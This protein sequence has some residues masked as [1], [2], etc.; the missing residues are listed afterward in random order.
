[1]NSQVNAQAEVGND[2]DL[3]GLWTS[4]DVTRWIAGIIAG[5]IAAAI[6]MSVGGLLA[7]SQGY[8]FVFPIKLFGTTVLGNTAT[9]YGNT[10]GLMVGAAVLGFITMFWGFVFGHFV[11]T[12]KFWGLFGM[13][14]TWGLFSWVFTWN[15]FMHAFTPINA[16]NVPPGPAMAVCLAYGFGMMTIAI[17]DKIIRR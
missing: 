17:V 11:R 3:V 8:E 15:L 10:Q 9:A 6:A 14:L 2:V 12:N 16:L 1:M 13:G 5:A 7:A 4:V